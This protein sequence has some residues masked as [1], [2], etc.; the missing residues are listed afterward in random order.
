MNNIFIKHTD[1]PKESI[2]Q[3]DVLNNNLPKEFYNEP[4]LNKQKDYTEWRIRHF[5]INKKRIV[6]I[7][8]LDNDKRLY[9]NK[10]NEWVE[11]NVSTEFDQYV[12]ETKYY[13]TSK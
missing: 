6:E 8:Y 9:L 2:C 3:L 12:I 7:S 11:R 4:Q 1:I 13:Y 5:L 10:N